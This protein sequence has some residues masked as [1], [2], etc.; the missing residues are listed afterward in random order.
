MGLNSTVCVLFL[1][2]WASILSKRTGAAKVCIHIFPA[3]FCS[4][5]IGAIDHLKSTATACLKMSFQ[6]AQ[7]SRPSAP[8]CTVGALHL[9]LIDLSVETSIRN[10]LKLGPL[11]SAMRTAFFALLCEPLLQTAT[12]VVLSTA[13]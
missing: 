6:V 9:E 13:H 10:V 4:A 12:A 5:L 2:V 8:W 1:A 7:L 11:R 3:L